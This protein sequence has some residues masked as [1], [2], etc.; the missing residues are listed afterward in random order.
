[1]VATLATLGVVACGG[2]GMP[3][4]P[5]PGGS[6]ALAEVQLMDADNGRSI[7]VA[8]GGTVIVALTSNRSTG[9]AWAV[10]VAP[11]PQLTQLGEAEYAPAGSSLPVVGA[12]GT[13]KFTFSATS[14][15]VVSLHLVY[16]RS[17]EPGV[18]PVRTF[19]VSVTVK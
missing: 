14:P 4:T 7:E 19:E 18:P 5:T 10:D 12:G 15:G 9:Y 8:S 3:A 13:E 2:D 16:R 6:T 17:F 11:G 1:L